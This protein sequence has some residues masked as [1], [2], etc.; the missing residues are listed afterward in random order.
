MGVVIGWGDSD[1]RISPTTPMPT[2]DNNILVAFQ[3]FAS[4]SPTDTASKTIS[5]VAGKNRRTKIHTYRHTDRKTERQN[6]RHKDSKQKLQT[7]T[8]WWLSKALLQ[9]LLQTLHQK[10]FHGL[11]VKT[12]EQKFIHTDR[13]T[14]RQKDRTTERQKDRQKDRHKDSKQKYLQQHS[15]GL[16][17]LC[18]RL[19]YRHC[20]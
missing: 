2:P 1:G 19:S 4:G 7:T 16:P 10:P 13:K 9:A 20:I 8:F 11:Q 17:K 12:E 14:E 3:S 5:R 15:G 18:F 6:D